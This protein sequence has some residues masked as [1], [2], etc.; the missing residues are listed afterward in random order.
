MKTRNYTQTKS[1][2][3]AGTAHGGQT[4]SLPAR[5]GVS[6]KKRFPL[7]MIVVTA[8]M[9]LGSDAFG[10]IS[11][12]NA[13]PVTENFDSMGATG[14]SAP[15]DWSWYHN[16][17]TVSNSTLVV[18]NGSAS[19][20]NGYNY[21][22]T[23]ASDRAIG[24]HS[25]GDFG[26][27]GYIQVNYQNNTGSAIDAFSVGYRLEQWQ[28]NANGNTETFKLE[29]S[30]DGSNWVN[31]GL[32]AN[33]P[34][35]ASTGQSDGNTLFSNEGGLYTPAAAIANGQQFYIRWVDANDSGNDT[36]MGLDDWSVTAS[37]PGS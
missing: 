4:P 13:S 29:Y 22:T 20:E 27:A 14:T 1:T 12:T 31:M 37:A 3:A 23:S 30:S 17:D 26:D 7:S 21:G 34:D 8:A 9:V 19:G 18:D 28:G 2:L 10:A 32:D 5:F 15:T 24:M 25:G 16:N 35:P 6:T 11:I 36:G 33:Q